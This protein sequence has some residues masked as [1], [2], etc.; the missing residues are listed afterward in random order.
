[1]L[2]CPPSSPYLTGSS[3]LPTIPI[4]FGAGSITIRCLCFH[5]CATTGR[6]CICLAHPCE[7]WSRPLAIGLCMGTATALGD[8]VS[9]GLWSSSGGKVWA[10]VRPQG[11]ENQ[12]KIISEAHAQ[13]NSIEQRLYGLHLSST[14]QSSW[15]TFPARIISDPAPALP[16]PDSL[17]DVLS[18]LSN[19]SFPLYYAMPCKNLYSEARVP[20]P[21]VKS[22]TS[23]DGTPLSTYKTTNIT[24]PKAAF[25]KKMI[26]T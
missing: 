1:M 20:N 22:S 4:A 19:C 25:P 6:T 14:Q 9:S 5:T 11:T 24:T 7:L 15:N 26:S 12:Q 8:I 18:S 23:F 2:L 21:L 10:R 3:L 13:H 17:V 16:P